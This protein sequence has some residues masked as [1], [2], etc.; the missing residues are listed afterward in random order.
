MSPV[1]SHKG[2]LL[3][4]GDV[5]GTTL[6]AKTVDGRHSP[7]LKGFDAYSDVGAGLMDPI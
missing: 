7:V 2:Y 4:L 5:T 6:R 3:S 1:D